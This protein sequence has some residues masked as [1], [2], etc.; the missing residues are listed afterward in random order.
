[1]LAGVAA[2]AVMTGFL[3]RWSVNVLAKRRD[4]EG[5]LASFV[6]AATVAAFMAVG[7]VIMVAF[8]VLDRI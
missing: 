5:T 4:D 1:M 3:V 6:T 2:F 7:L 8:A